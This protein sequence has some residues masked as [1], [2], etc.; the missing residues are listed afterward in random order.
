MQSE[1]VAKTH[2]AAGVTPAVPWRVR[3]VGVLPAWR[4]TVTFNDGITGI[5]DLE[6]VVCSSDAGIFE[7][8]RDSDFFAKAFLDCGAIAWPNGADLAPEVMYEE[9]RRS[10]IWRG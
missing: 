8:L 10:G 6:G 4:L 1:S 5:V 3:A 2:Q 7:A 9:I